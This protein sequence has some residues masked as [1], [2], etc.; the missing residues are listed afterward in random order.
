MNFFVTEHSKHNQSD[1]SQS[2]QQQPTADE[3]V[4]EDR[5]H[6]GDV[7]P[8][9]HQEEKNGLDNPV[10]QQEEM[11][12]DQEDNAD[13]E[14]DK[15]NLDEEMEEDVTLSEGE[16]CD[17][18]DGVETGEAEEI[19]GMETEEA[20]EVDAVK[21]REAEEIEGVKTGEAGEIESAVMGQ[22]NVPAAV[23]DLNDQANSEVGQEGKEIDTTQ[24]SEQEAGKVTSAATVKHSQVYTLIYVCVN[25]DWPCSVSKGCL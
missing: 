12:Q 19:E 11:E 4:L 13:T 8:L 17:Q 7:D 16:D 6:K 9:P 2:H 24:P 22:D 15:E 14:V 25:T 10:L 18:T 23:E 3:E 5:E 21:T 1:I 20:V